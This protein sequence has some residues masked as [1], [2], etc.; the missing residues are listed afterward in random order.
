MNR[1]VVAIVGALIGAIVVIV[2]VGGTNG[3]SPDS[4]EPTAT[5]V[6]VT[7]PE[8]TVRP[9]S[10]PALVEAIEPSTVPVA[11]ATA[12]PTPTATA[13]PTPTPTASPSPIPA[14]V[15]L[16]LLKP[17]V[18]GATRVKYFGITGE[19]P[20]AL[21][22]D[23]V[24]RSR[25]SCKSADTLACVLQRPRV[26]WTNR[27]LL[28]T[29]ACTIVAPRVSLTSTA[30]LPQWE[31]PKR[32]QPALLAWWHKVVDH[33]AWHEAQHIRIQRSYDSKLMRLMAGHKCSSANRI[34]RNWKRSLRAA[35]DKFDAKDAR[36]PYP[37]YTG[38]GGFYGS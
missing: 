26:Q 13:S 16:P 34:Y 33:L 29:G 37:D 23:V 10:R 12:S 9:T 7:T 21:L 15:R 6:A 25:V 19:S 1:K 24:L 20:A 11:V 14:T 36:W 22:D 27:T 30:H 2:A 35:Q 31:R 3:G 32:V 5:A 8:V 17:K 28:A 18:A 4:V 38:P